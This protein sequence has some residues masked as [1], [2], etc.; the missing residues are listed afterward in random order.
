MINP[1][2]ILLLLLGSYLEK[3][4]TFVLSS[5]VVFRM[6]TAAKCS[7]EKCEQN[8]YFSF[9]KFAK[10]SSHRHCVSLI[11]FKETGADWLR[12]QTKNKE[13]SF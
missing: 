9:F 8:Y 4:L 5:S 3:N 7:N 11:Y 10:C 1:I 12:F 13:D 6:R 2:T